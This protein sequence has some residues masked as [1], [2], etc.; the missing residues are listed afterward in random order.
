MKFTKTEISKG[1]FSSVK[2]INNSETDKIH[3]KCYHFDVCL[4]NGHGKSNL[5]GVATDQFPGLKIIK[6]PKKFFTIMNEPVLNKFMCYADH[7][8]NNRNDFN[9]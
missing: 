1:I 6:R 4:V 9:Y 3:I 8:K 2:P 7:D 5:Y